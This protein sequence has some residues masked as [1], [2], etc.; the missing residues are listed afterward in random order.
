MNTIQSLVGLIPKGENDTHLIFHSSY[1]RSKGV[2]SINS[3]TPKDKC[4]V[5][6]KDVAQAIQLCIKEG[7]G[8]F[9]KIADMKSAFRNLPIGKQDWCLL[10][11]KAKDPLDG[12][13][14]YFTDKYLP[15]GA[16]ISC[17]HFQQFSNC[18]EY[19]FLEKD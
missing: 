12:K 3:G 6:Y 18:V 2:Q 14:Y 11:M 7:H 4:T 5:N 8:C 16:S 19:I 17:S 10:V 13:T 1:P 9:T 15:F